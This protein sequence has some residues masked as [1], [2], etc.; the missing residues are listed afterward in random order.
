MKYTSEY[1]NS[2][3]FKSYLELMAT[4]LNENGFRE[5]NGMKYMVDADPKFM[6]LFIM[7]PVQDQNAM[8]FLKRQGLI[9]NGRCPQC[10]APMSVNQYFWYDRRNPSRRFYVC[11]GCSKSNGQGD[12]HSMDGCPSGIPKNKSNTGCLLTLLT[13]PILF[14]QSHSSLY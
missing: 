10:G 13:L 11:Y 5:F 3:S 1:I 9:E 8:D 4:E 14:T 12:G 6:D 2:L 7:G